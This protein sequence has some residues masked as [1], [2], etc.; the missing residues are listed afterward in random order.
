MSKP[1]ISFFSFI[2]AGFDSRVDDTL[3]GFKVDDDG[4]RELTRIMIEIANIA[5][6]GRL[7]SLLEGGYNT[8][9][10]AMG[11]YAH[12]DEMCKA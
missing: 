10:L 12:I 1:T 6:E 9:G 4:F 2:S 8:K 5:G 11:V 7:I 3:G